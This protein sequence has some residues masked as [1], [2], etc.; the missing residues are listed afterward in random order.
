MDTNKLKDD[1][2]HGSF[3][4]ESKISDNSIRL[5]LSFEDALKLNLS[6]ESALLNVNKTKKN[7]KQGKEHH[8]LI[9]SFESPHSDTKTFQVW[10][11][12]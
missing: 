8:I 12:L 11:E 6:L 10:D 2:Y 7:S 5:T 3:N 4:C 9:Q 1:S